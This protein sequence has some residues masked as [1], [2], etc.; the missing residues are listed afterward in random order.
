MVQKP[1]H[2]RQSCYSFFGFRIDF[3]YLFLGFTAT[4]FS[5][6]THLVITDSIGDTTRWS[7]SRKTERDYWRGSGRA[8]AGVHELI[9]N[10]PQLRHLWVNERILAIPS[11]YND[12]DLLDAK[13]F[14][15]S[16]DAIM[17]RTVNDPRWTLLRCAF[18]RLES[19]RVGFGPLNS[20]WVAVVLSLCDSTKLKA[21]GFDWEWRH[22]SNTPVRT[23]VLQ[24]HLH[25]L[26]NQSFRASS[27]S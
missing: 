16:Q 23:L 25:E 8:Y 14:E 6:L 13:P 9:S 24:I 12:D 4:D 7:I 21:F 3:A 26:I 22:G 27:P 11:S 5:S 1:L 15:E 18:E 19:L 2:L 10:L 17:S 20:T